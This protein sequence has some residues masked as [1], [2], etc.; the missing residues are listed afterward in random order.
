[1]VDSSANVKGYVHNPL[2]YLPLNSQG[3]YDVAGAVGNGYLNVIKDLGLR[4]PY[5]GHV[6]LVSGE[7]ARILHIIMHILNKFPRPLLWEC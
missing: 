3:K 5:V 6:D 1:V 2:V 7:I 4:E